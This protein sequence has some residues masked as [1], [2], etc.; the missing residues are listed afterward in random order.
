MTKND[1][2][3]IPLNGSEAAAVASV[4]KQ[5][6]KSGLEPNTAGVRKLVRDVREKSG[7]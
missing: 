2:W 7:N 1:K 6:K 4:K 5:M 3:Q